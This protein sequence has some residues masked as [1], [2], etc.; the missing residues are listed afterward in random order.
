MLLHICIEQGEASGEAT[1]LFRLSPSGCCLLLLCC[2][3]GALLV[4]LLLPCPEP[5][6]CSMGQRSLS[7]LLLLNAAAPQR[8]LPP[9]PGCLVSPTLRV[10]RHAVDNPTQPWDLRS[11]ANVGLPCSRMLAGST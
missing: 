9:N 1:A 6:G 2:L 11:H 5:P 10:L 3:A 7:V 4:C 8:P